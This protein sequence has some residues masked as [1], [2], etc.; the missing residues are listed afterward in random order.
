VD[1]ILV[2]GIDGDADLGGATEAFVFGKVPN[3]LRWAW[4]TRSLDPG[5]LVMAGTGQRRSSV[6]V[7]MTHPVRLALDLY[8]AS[9]AVAGRELL[10][11]DRVS[12]HVRAGCRGRRRTG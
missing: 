7:V 3:S 12:G 11:N 10:S 6:D 1:A 4:W 5:G 9:M 2:S 8:S